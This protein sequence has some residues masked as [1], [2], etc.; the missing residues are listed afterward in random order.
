MSTIYKQARL[1]TE[2]LYELKHLMGGV[3]SLLALWSLASLSMG[4]EILLV[5][6]FALLAVNVLKPALVLRLPSVT[7]KLAGPLLLVLIAADF[8]IHLPEFIPSLIR[9]VILLLIYRN[10]APRTKREDLQLILLCLFCL[11]MSGVMTVSLLFAFQILLFTPLAMALLF[12]ICI[13]D[14]GEDAGAYQLTWQQ[15]KWGRL[16]R[17]VCRVLDFK[18]VV[19]GTSMF[20]FVVLVSTFL[21]ILTPRFNL[22]QAI[23]LLEMQADAITGF[24]ED[25][26][27]GDVSAIQENNSVAMRIDVPSLE[28]ISSQPYW[29][30]L[31][32][33][34]YNRGRFQMSRSLKGPDFRKSTTA[35]ELWM[36]G[37]DPRERSGALWTFYMEGGISRYL[38]VAGDFSV[39][40]FQAPQ[41]VELL[42]EPRIYGLDAVGQSV[43]SYQVEDMQFNARFPAGQ[44]ESEAFGTGAAGPT[45]GEPEYPFTLLELNL[46]SDER[47]Y[48]SGLNR[49][50]LNGRAI[51]TAAY[52][53]ELTEFL[54]QRF[55]YSLRPD[56]QVNRS[57]VDEIDPVVNWLREGTRGHCELFAGAF[58]LMARDAG[59]PARMVVGFAGGSWNAVEDYFLVRNR[60]AHAW[61][62]IYDQERDEWLRVDPTPRSGSSDPEAPLR[63]SFQFEAGWTAWLDSLRI[64]WYRRIVN[65]EQQDQVEIATSLK[66]WVEEFS[67]RFKLRVEEAVSELKSWL[68]QPFSA[69][70]VSLALLV[71]PAVLVLVF[72]WRARDWLM[73]LVFKVLKKPRQLDPVR[74]KASRQIKRLREAHGESFDSP[75]LRELE[76]LRFGP[77]VDSDRAREI[78][79]RAQKAIRR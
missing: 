18:L 69:G 9:M 45:S 30:M 11:V 58:V 23:P 27:L 2:E 77:A 39:L 61:A 79:L 7:W 62:E 40:R 28:A 41:D 72:F 26:Q 76:S 37:F 53:Q 17:R 13:L 42:A 52:A 6:A 51:S 3:I 74:R 50:I 73:G 46:G 22:D 15:F 57:G 8:L 16:L 67:V 65:F 14:R 19:L 31:V 38:P 56:G 63:G 60:E 64:Q 25:V 71:V 35:R 43:L 12:V 10:L 54:W 44:V 4:L 68:S 49:D 33:D 48:L 29:R 32:L 66:E 55:S 75:V 21:F 34:R 5:L 47:A 59:Y 70:T 78:F 20:A 36:S 24:S 1:T